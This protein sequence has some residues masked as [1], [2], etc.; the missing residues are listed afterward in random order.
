ML[1]S[2]GNQTSMLTWKKCFDQRRMAGSRMLVSRSLLQNW[3]NSM[4]MFL[5]ECCFELKQMRG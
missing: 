1:K 5:E 2:L 4:K 3:G